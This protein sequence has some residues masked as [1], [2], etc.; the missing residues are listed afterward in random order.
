MYYMRYCRSILFTSAIHCHRFAKARTSGADVCLVDCEDSVSRRDKAKARLAAAEFFPDE[1]EGEPRLGIRVNGLCDEEGL[2]DLLAVR[3]WPRRPEVIM[4]PKV[5]SPRDIE[6]VLGVLGEKF[7]NVELMAVIE[8]ARGI[9][10]VAAIAKASPALKAIVFGSADFSMSI[11]STMCWEALYAGRAQVVLAARAAGIH[12][13]DTAVFDIH[14]TSALAEEARRI[15]DMGFSGKA[16]IHPVQVAV[17]NEIFSPDAE[18]LA[19][20][21]RIV[22]EAEANE[23]NICVVDGM[24]VGTPIVA[25]AR[26]TLAEFADAGDR[27]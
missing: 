15:R 26:R 3:A 5:E 14:A 13:V 6:I 20:A 23:G 24:M 4:V 18:K 2:A 1:R 7:Q 27:R 9:Q 12:A 21:R 22:K 11:N 10:N 8:T 16:A 25:A 17:I 19:W